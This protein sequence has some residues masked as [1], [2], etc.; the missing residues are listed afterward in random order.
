VLL[1]VG[2]DRLSALEGLSARLPLSVAAIGLA[3]YSL[4]GLPP[5]GGFTAKWLMLLAAVE[6]GAWWWAAVLV[7]G[8]LLTA[9]YMLRV[10]WPAFGRD[11]APE[12]PRAIPRTMELAALG[13]ALAAVAL[14]VRAEE[15]ILLLEVGL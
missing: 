15:L 12:A 5:S 6:Q 9:A 8:G 10:M 14:G 3:G 4:A 2:N 11:P 13:L 1:S 7:L